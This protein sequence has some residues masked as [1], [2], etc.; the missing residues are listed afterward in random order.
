VKR[1]ILGYCLSAA[2][3]YIAMNYFTHM[4]LQMLYNFS[5]VIV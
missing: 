1:K 3:V 4:F 5:G 2:S